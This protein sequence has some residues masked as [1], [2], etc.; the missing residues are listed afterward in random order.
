VASYLVVVD[1]ADER[2]VAIVG[3][4]NLERVLDAAGLDK[5]VA[6]GA[7][8]PTDDHRLSETVAETGGDT[9]EVTIAGHQDEGANLRPV[10]HRVHDVDHHVQVG[11]ALPATAG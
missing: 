11:R 9:D 3:A 10:E 2:F 8:H 5:I 7:W 1:L 6:E 4:R